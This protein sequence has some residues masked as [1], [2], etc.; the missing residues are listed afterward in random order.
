[1]TSVSVFGLQYGTAKQYAE[2][3]ARRTGIAARQHDSVGDRRLPENKKNA[4]VR[5]MLETYGR[6]PR[7]S[8]LLPSPARPW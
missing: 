2:E 8:S 4:E 7:I 1:M 3:L 5:A 6:I